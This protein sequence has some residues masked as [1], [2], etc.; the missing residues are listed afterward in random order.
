MIATSY[1]GQHMCEHRRGKYIHKC[2]DCGSVYKTLGSL[3]LHRNQKHLK[4]ELK[5]PFDSCAKIFFQRKVLKNH[6]DSVHGDR[7]RYQCNKCDKSF[8]INADLAT[9]VRGVHEGLKAYC[10]FC[11]KDFVRPSEKNRHEKQ[12]HK[13][14][15]LIQKSQHEDDDKID[16]M[17]S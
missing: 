17:R 7:E 6:I 11:G 3:K 12:V 16:D 1:M 14:E 15:A 8:A 13:R 9:H 4:I 10:R 5:C 2:Q